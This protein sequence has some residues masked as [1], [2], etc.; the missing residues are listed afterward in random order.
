[1]FALF[2]CCCVESDQSI[3]VDKSSDINYATSEKHVVQK[4]PLQDV[5]APA[6]QEDV[7]VRSKAGM[8]TFDVTVVRSAS[9]YFG[10]DLSTAKHVCMVNEVE[11]DSLIHDYNCSCRADAQVRRYD[12]ILGFD[13][14]TC[15]RGADMVEKLKTASGTVRLTFQRPVV[16]RAAFRKG[17][18]G[19]VG[20][21][22]K[23]GPRFLLI[24][25]IASGSVEEFNKT[26]LPDQVVTT[27]CL[28]VSVNG[29][30]GSGKKLLNELSAAQGDT[31]TLEYVSWKSG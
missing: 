20:L 28:I 30:T 22:L 10:M 21:A 8:E 27:S 6:V 23:T 7:S 4:Q 5:E 17:S 9:S 12:R 14:A 16:N 13:G 18:D 29:V 25:G 1:M 26:A 15:A 24:V 3:T 11:P 31:I 19:S 2:G